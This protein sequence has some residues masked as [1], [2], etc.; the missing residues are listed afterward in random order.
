VHPDRRLRGLA[1]TLAMLWPVASGVAVG[2]A[3]VVG[4]GAPAPSDAFLGAM[5]EGERAYSAGRYAEAAESYHRAAAL[6][7]RVKDRDE[8]LF[9]EGRLYLKLGRID[10]AVATYRRLV[11]VSPDGPRT[12]RAI[13][14]L[15]AIEIEHGDAARGWAA[16]EA[17]VRRYPNHGSARKA[18]SDVVRHKAETEGEPAA[19][20]FLEQ[21]QPGFEATEAAQQGRYELGLSLERSGELGR[22]RDLFLE[23]ARAYPYPFGNLTDDAYWHAALIDDKLGRYQEAVAELREMIGPQE[24]GITGASYDRPRFPHAQWRMAKIYRDELKDPAS[25]RREFHRMFEQHPAA[26]VADDALWQEALL[27]RRAKDDADVCG[28]MK[29]LR[30]HYPKSRYLRCADRL[31]PGEKPTDIE[32]GCPPY[33]ERTITGET[34]DVTDEEPADKEEANAPDNG[35]E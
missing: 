28:L 7:D 9:L 22:A 12:V 2:A 24:A 21:A 20:R 34:V 4:C 35:S 30:D 3:A 10:Q 19:R 25:A 16:L 5:A 32:R 23:L 13:F 15:A 6:G 1:L 17:A 18:L 33:I 11:S 8:A 31:C 26:S 29:L 27:A 14:E